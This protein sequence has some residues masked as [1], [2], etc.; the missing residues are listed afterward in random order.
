M[1]NIGHFGQ[2]CAII[3]VSLALVWFGL[4]LH[5]HHGIFWAALS[6]DNGTWQAAD[7]PFV[8]RLT[9]AFA[10]PPTQSWKM[11]EI[12]PEVASN[13]IPEF[14]FDVVFCVQNYSNLLWGA[15]LMNVLWDTNAGNTFFSSSLFLVFGGWKLQRVNFVFFKAWPSHDLPSEGSRL[16]VP[17][18][19]TLI[20]VTGREECR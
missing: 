19:K 8:C 9:S 5:R 2:F 10:P 13:S 1:P 15:K 16:S 3:L 6:W 18:Q 14:Q 12:F 17:S 11:L 20:S 4:H 7:F